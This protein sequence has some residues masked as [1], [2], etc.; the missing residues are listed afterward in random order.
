M[1]KLLAILKSDPVR[2]CR[3]CS[4]Y[5]SSRFLYGCKHCSKETEVINELKNGFLAAFRLLM[6]LPL[7]ISWMLLYGLIALSYGIV[8]ADMFVMMWNAFVYNDTP[9]DEQCPLDP[10][11]RRV[12]KSGA[13]CCG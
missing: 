5:R 9:V 4:G 8:R 3:E 7:A 13:C 2:S 1:K 10:S 11:G 12:C 6:C